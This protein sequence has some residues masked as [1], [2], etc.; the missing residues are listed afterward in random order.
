M[1]FSVKKFREEVPI[2]GTC[3]FCGEIL[4]RDNAAV[5]HIIPPRLGGTNDFENLRYLCSVCNAKK[6]DKYDPLLEYYVRLMKA[7]GKADKESGERI[8]HLLRNATEND[9]DALSARIEKI[10]P[11]FKRIQAYYNALSEHQRGKIEEA[12]PTSD[13]LAESMEKRLKA[14]D[15]YDYKKELRKEINGN[16]FVYAN[17]FPID[18]YIDVLSSY[19]DEEVGEV[20]SVYLDEEGEL[21]VY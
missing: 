19:G 9:L 18:N 5:D 4:T 16:V 20:Y 1:R 6:A 21:V 3:P 11:A 7:K 12:E 10:D 17:D 2:S 13:E 8:E 15:N 14:Y